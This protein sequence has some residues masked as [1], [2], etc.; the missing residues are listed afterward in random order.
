MNSENIKKKIPMSLT[1]SRIAVLPFI[2]IFI[3]QHTLVFNILAA[4]LFVLASLTD[5]WDGKLARKYDAVTTMGKFMDPLADK[6]LISG[7]L[8]FMIP[9]GHVDPIVVVILICRDILI[10]GI[11]TVAAVD[12]IIIAAKPMGK[13]KAALQMIAI[14]EIIVGGSLFT[15]DL[16][17]IGYWTLWISVILSILSGIDYYFGYLKSKR[18]QLDGPSLDHK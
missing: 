15:V 13:W 9:G 17:I 6:I 5:F 11:R 1:M 3:H 4:I 16:S 10:D 7:T 14:P 18:K 12:K 8:I 2:I